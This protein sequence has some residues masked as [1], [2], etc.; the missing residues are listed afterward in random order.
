LARLTYRP[1]R[2]IQLYGQFRQEVREK[3]YRNEDDTNPSNFNKITPY[4]RRNYQLNCDYKAEEIVSLR[5]RVQFSSYEHEA[6][7]TQGYVLVQ[8][9][10]LD[11]GKVRFSTRFALF[12]TDDYENRQYVY[13]KDVLYYFFIPA[14]YGRGFRNFYMI[15]I[16]AGKKI[17]IWAKWA[18]TKYRN[19]ETIGS[20]L[21]RI[22]GDLRNDIRIQMRINF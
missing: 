12:D 11:F 9:V 3:N 10:N 1:S 18:Y 2:A 19:Q 5:A 17:D 6:P 13:E 16:K 14:Y 7:K 20:G 22:E 15:Q 4:T 8:D 21:E